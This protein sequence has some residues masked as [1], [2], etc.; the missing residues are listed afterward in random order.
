[1]LR[2]KH[3]LWPIGLLVVCLA[4]G[5]SSDDK[6][7][8]GNGTTVPSPT[9]ATID[10]PTA[11][12]QSSN[13]MAQMA[14]GY[15]N[16]A[17]AIGGYGTFFSPPAGAGKLSNLSFSAA[18]TTTYTWTVDSFTIKM[19][20]WETTLKYHWRAILDGYD[21]AYTY[22]N[23]VFIDAEETK[24]GTSGQFVVYEPITTNVACL[25]EWS[26]DAQ[27]VYTLTFTYDDFYRIEFAIN[28]DGSGSLYFYEDN[29]LVVKIV[30]TADGSGEWWTYEY[31][32]QTGHGTWT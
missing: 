21:G 25:W 5:C 23:W 26:I 13:S 20:F 2:K 16:L 14:V 4:L 15:I 30:W 7:T 19:L 31:G 12:Q 8:N 27:G 28:P 10:V 1:M 17:N 32:S 18:D 24:D 22:S 6:G 11:M 9:R 29:I 3:L